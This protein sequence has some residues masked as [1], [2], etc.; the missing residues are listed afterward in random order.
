MS[1]S[2]NPRV[3]SMQ[4]SA[5]LA[6]AGRAKKL[7]RAG[8]DVIALSAGEPDFNTPE[9]IAE[10][11][12]QA[13]RDGF[14]RYTQNPGMPEL[15]EA[16]C[17]KF[18]RENNLEYT[19]DQILCSNGAK[20]SVAL[21]VSVLAA[22]TDEV[23]IPAPYWVSYPEMTRFAGASP[24]I[25]HTTAETQYRLTPQ[26]LA[27]AIT[28]RTRVL[29]LCSPSNPTGSVYTLEELSALAEV[30]HKHEKIVV[31]SDEIYEHV[32][33][34]AVHIPIA[35]LPG[36]QERTITVN[37]FSKCFAMTGWRLGYMA[38]PVEIVKQAAK[39]QG[40]FT[41]APS[42]ISQR[43]GIAALNMHQGPIRAMVQAFRERRDYLLERL[44]A[45][46]GVNVP[47]P[48]GAFYLFPQ[49]SDYYGTVAPSGRVIN[50][51]DDL[52]FY[53]LEEH[54]VALVPGAAFGDP[55]GIRISYASSMED[56]QKASDRIETG[57]KELTRN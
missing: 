3:A 45:L 17:A 51:S 6:M 34:D 19:S 10:A 13:I 47:K 30:L 2:F 39:L 8:A 21:A 57:L 35:S 48:E 4:P 29:I 11:G 33:Y 40:Q 9:P 42:S 56:L 55:D 16:I 52:C 41:S 46:P 25:A 49:V 20:Q 28:E 43:A 27:D 38:G 36:M 24:V 54:L 14:T 53:L 5:T 50:S 32:I 15:R 37:G 18:A 23:L 44:R 12:I 26:A 1:G 7:K 31:V 22:E